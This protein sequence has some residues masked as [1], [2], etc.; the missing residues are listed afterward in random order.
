[1]PP[2]KSVTHRAVICAGLTQGESVLRNISESED[3]EATLRCMRTLEAHCVRK[4][5]EVVIRGGGMHHAQGTTH[6]TQSEGMDTPLLLDC[7]ESGSTLRFLMPL[8]ACLGQP[9]SFTGNGRLMERPL[10][11]YSDLFREYGVGVVRRSSIDI[12]AQSL[13]RVTLTVTG[14]LQG[15]EFRL[16]GHISSQFVS[17]LLLALPLLSQDSTVV[18]TTPLESASYVDITLDVMRAF[19]VEVRHREYQEFFIRGNQCYQACDYTVEGDYSQAA[20]FLVAAALGCNCVCAGLKE[21][22]CQGDRRIVHILRQCGADVSWEECSYAADDLSRECSSEKGKGLCVRPRELSCVTVDISDIPDLAAPLAVL[23]SFCRGESR[24]IN[25]RRLRYKESDRLTA[26][27]TELRKLG[28]DIEEGE[29]FLVIRGVDAFTGG[30]VDS[31]GD[32]RIAMMLSVAALKSTG[33]VWLTGSQSVAKSY[34][35]F[36]EDFGKVAAEK[37]K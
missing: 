29:D 36:F 20:F 30:Q 15:G 28:A 24:I 14:P 31:W 37:V 3:I 27:A 11:P 25:G 19:G 17:G 22:S 7:G 2:S 32:H 12:A 35:D 5:N 10:E 26:V 34:P 21:D 6:N 16:P 8:A 4:G 18:M 9:V 23:F 13:E 1:M 33:P